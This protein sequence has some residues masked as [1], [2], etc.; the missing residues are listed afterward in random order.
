M[1]DMHRSWG[2]NLPSLG[3]RFQAR[4]RVQASVRIGSSFRGSLGM[5]TM[6]RV[7]LKASWSQVLCSCGA[8]S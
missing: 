3:P 2:C 8:V 1:V 6:T 4:F 5:R 7:C